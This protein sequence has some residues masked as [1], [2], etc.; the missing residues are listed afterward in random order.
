MS[1]P[2]RH[3]VLFRFGTDAPPEQVAELI[4]QF[5]GLA[6]LIPEVLGFEAGANISS[7]GLDQGYTHCFLIRFEDEAARDRYLQH[8]AHQSFVAAV[9]PRLE[10]ALVVDFFGA[11]P[12]AFQ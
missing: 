2:L 12:G 11:N 7:E 10:Q 8:P 4:A 5:G 9:T 3:L 6:T 1:S